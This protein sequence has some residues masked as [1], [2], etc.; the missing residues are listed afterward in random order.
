MK[1]NFFTRYSFDKED[2]EKI[3]AI[4]EIDD[5]LF[6]LIESHIIDKK[7]IRSASDNEIRELVKSSGV[8]AGVILNSVNRVF[9]L[10]RLLANNYQDSIQD[11]TDDIKELYPNAV[12]DETTLVSRFEKINHIAFDFRPLL[13]TN[14]VKKEG[15]PTLEETSTTVVLKPVF[16]ERFDFDKIDI[17]D[18]KPKRMKQV[19]LAVIELKNSYDNYFTFQLDSFEFEQF[20]NDL[21]ALQIELKT[22]EDEC[23]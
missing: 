18:Y 4:Q 16:E 1:T 23:E 19:A 13:K 17:K 11:F 7:A 3:L 20:L 12:K 5:S 2:Q 14:R 22:F 6:N 21:I 10:V 15:L 9:W 8:E